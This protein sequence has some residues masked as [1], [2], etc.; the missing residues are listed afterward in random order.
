MKLWI[1]LPLGQLLGQNE[2]GWRVRGFIYTIPFHPVF[3][4]TSRWQLGWD[5]TR[6]ELRITSLSHY[7]YI[8][9]YLSSVLFKIMAGIP[10]FMFQKWKQ[11]IYMKMWPPL[12]QLIVSFS[13]HIPQ[14]HKTILIVMLDVLFDS[15][16]P[17]IWRNASNVGQFDYNHLR[18][19]LCKLFIIFLLIGYMK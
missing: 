5:E 19:I 11:L 2:F 8:I 4:S 13:S 17:S 18:N 14:M 3:F 12:S 10:I 15:S 6:W 9:S 16:F 7:I 1:L